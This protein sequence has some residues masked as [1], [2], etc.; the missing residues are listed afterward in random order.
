[1]IVQYLCIVK[2]LHNIVTV[3]LYFDHQQKFTSSCSDDDPE[4]SSIRSSNTGS[5]EVMQVKFKRSYNIYF[6][7]AFSTM[8]KHSMGHK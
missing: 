4:E 7:I 1:M 8:F 5:V 2:L 6:G 3:Q